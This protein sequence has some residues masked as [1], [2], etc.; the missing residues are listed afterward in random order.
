MIPVLQQANCILVI[1]APE[2]TLGLK[3]TVAVKSCSAP[4]RRVKIKAH[5]TNIVLMKTK[6]SAFD[7][8][9]PLLLVGTMQQCVKKT[10]AVSINQDVLNQKYIYKR[11]GLGREGGKEAGKEAE[12][13]LCPKA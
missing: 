13:S 2:Q 1:P 9:Q 4:G 11:W 10:G 7:V 8:G 5:S 12:V 6:C 3:F